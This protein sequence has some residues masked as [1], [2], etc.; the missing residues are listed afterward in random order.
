MKKGLSFKDRNGGEYEFDNDDEYEVMGDEGN[1]LPSPF[2]DVAAET[3]GVLTEREEV[4]GVDEVVQADLLPTDEERAMLAARNSGLDIGPLVNERPARP[5]VIDLLGEEDEVALDEHINEEVLPKVEAEAEHDGDVRRS[6]RTRIAPS[7]YDPSTGRD[8]ELYTTVEEEE[9]MSIKGTD[10]DDQEHLAP[11]AHY[12]MMHYAEKDSIKKKKRRFKPKQGQFGLEAGLKHFGD[13]V[14]TAVTKEL[15]QFNSYDVFEPLEAER[16]TKEEREKALTSLIFLKEKQNGDVKARSCAN[17]SVQREHVAKEEAAAPTVCLESVFATATIDAKER[18]KVVTIDIPG[19]FLHADN[20][21]F[22]IMK[23]NGTLV[24]LMVKTDPK[25]YRKYFVLEKGRQ[26]FYLRLQKALYGMM[27]S[28]LL[29]YRKLVGELR[30]MGFKLN[31]YDPCVANMM[32]DGAQ[33][34]VRWHVDD[35]MISHVNSDV[36]MTFIK[37]IKVIYGNNLAE[38]MGTKHT[39]LGMEFDYSCIGEVKISMQ[40]Y[41]T[42]IIE[43]F[44]EEITSTSATPAADYLFVVREDGRKLNEEQATAFHHTVYQLLFAANRARRDIQTAVSFLTTRVQE[45]DEDDW[46]KLKRVL[47][48]LKGTRYLKLTLSADSMNFVIHW[49]IDGSHQ[50]HED[51]RGQIGSLVTF[52][53]GAVSSSSNKMKCNTKSSTETEIISLGDKLS[54]VVWMRYFIEC[55]G[56]DIDECVIFQDNMS[57]LSMEKNGRISASKR[58]KHIKAKY[59]LI[60]DYYDA[61][62]IDLKYCPTETMW[63]DVLTKPLQGQKFRDMR[64]FLQNCPRDYDDDTE[65]QSVLSMSHQATADASSRECVSAQAKPRSNPTTKPS[66]SSSPNCVSRI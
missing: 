53:K 42:K 56:Y 16:L 1:M 51:C 21:D 18:R 45:P 13:R 63:A 47:K 58:S 17:G 12:I 57:A 11:V 54:D 2:P 7:R 4:F 19:A 65:R 35:L 43:E 46:G 39:Y 31:P 49:Y 62:E 33:L 50:V 40:K 61:K 44:P 64:A 25:L 14:E 28:A 8:Y 23:M 10:E 24:E 29:F 30:E 32:V 15:S 5:E 66:R 34:T 26:V 20:E 36:I 6:T 27:K 48:Y 3:P 55:Q 38:S 41:I 60:K 59:F 9:D 37:A 52:G 22:V